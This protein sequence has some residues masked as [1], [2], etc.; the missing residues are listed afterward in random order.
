[1]IGRRPLAA[2]LLSLIA[3]LGIA[4]GGDEGARPALDYPKDELDAA[5][6]QIEQRLAGCADPL[7]CA[8]RYV[9]IAIL[10]RPGGALEGLA[11]Y[12]LD[13]EIVPA[14]RALVA[15]AVRRDIDGTTRAR[16]LDLFHRH[17]TSLTTGVDPV[18]AEMVVLGLESDEPRARASAARLMAERPIPRIGH[19]AVDAAIAHP[20][21]TQAALLAIE[22]ANQTLVRSWVIDQLS[23][24][25]EVVRNTAR[26]TVAVLGREAMA[27]PLHSAIGEG[28]LA[29]VQ[30]ALEALLPIATFDDLSVLYRF[31]EKHGQAAPAMNDRVLAVIAELEAGLYRPTLPPPVPLDLARLG[32]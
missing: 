31:L 28:E 10:E 26:R 6:A 9:E 17:W 4:L 23:S 32:F 5:R 29:T 7:E 2:A 25:D 12:L 1:M 30:G 16:V 8:G 13:A 24:Q 14:R 22:L 20:E 3:A 15:I 27:E 11:S 19:Y 21:L 18:L